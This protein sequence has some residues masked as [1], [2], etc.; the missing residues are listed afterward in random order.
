MK[1]ELGMHVRYS[2]EQTKGCFFPSEAPITGYRYYRT[3][4]IDMLYQD[5]K[6]S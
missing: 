4:Y 3:A 5:T 1:K 2:A 6:L